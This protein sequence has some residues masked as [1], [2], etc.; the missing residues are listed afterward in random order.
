MR[1]SF[2]LMRFYFSHEHVSKK[3]THVPLRLTLSDAL[4]DVLHDVTCTKLTPP[5]LLQR[6]VL[7]APVLVGSTEV[8]IGDDGVAIVRA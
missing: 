6:S 1:R 3:A 2:V 5:T 4:W 8:L 7:E